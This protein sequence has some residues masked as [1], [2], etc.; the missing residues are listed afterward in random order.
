MT[1]AIEGG[2]VLARSAPGEVGPYGEPGPDRGMAAAIVG[3]RPDR[4]FIV[5]YPAGRVIS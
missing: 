2:K 1:L 4:T 3:G 5:W